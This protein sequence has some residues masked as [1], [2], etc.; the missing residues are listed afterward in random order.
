MPSFLTRV[1]HPDGVRTQRVDAPD[2]QAVAAALG[3][4]PQ[5]VLEVTELGATGAAATTGSAGAAGLRRLGI[6]RASSKRF[7]LQLFSQ[8]LAVLL[9]AGIAL[10]EALNTLREKEGNGAVRQALDGVIQAVEQGQPLSAAMRQQPQAFDE[11]VCAIVAANE[12]TGQLSASLAQHSRYLAWVES[13]RAKLIAACVYPVMLLGVGSAV[14][15]FLLLY[16]LPRFAG[17]LDGLG[18]DLPWASRV[19]IQ[20]G[21]TAG[22]HPLWVLGGIAGLAVA[23]LALWRHPALR[24]RVQASLWT[25][26]GLGPRLRVLALARLYRSLAMLLAS[27]VPVLASL[28]IVQDVIAAP[29]RPAVAAAAA[30]IERG[31]R[32]SEAL[33]AQDLATPV[34][35]RMV[36]VGERSG[37]VAAMLERAAAFHDEEA[38]RLTELLTRAI[39]PALMLLMGILIGGIIV[40]MY[41]P[42]FQL[43]EQVQ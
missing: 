3:V 41:L 20:F 1:Y 5:H 36:R 14:I 18:N 12:R 35:R 8:E 30:Q 25:L 43:V 23:V 13:L 6:S 31:E 29:W 37:E 33:E 22:A 34:A 10:L 11:L 9:D 15:L 16:V 39:N 2:A 4:L 32:L 28:R 42:I 38:Q 21:Q 26:P 7:P 27:G 19:L 17:I 24:E 40:L